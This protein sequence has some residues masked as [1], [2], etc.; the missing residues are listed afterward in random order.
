MPDHAVESPGSEA[1]DGA[2]AASEDAVLQSILDNWEESL[3]RFVKVMPKDYKR[4]LAQM[5]A[6]QQG[7][8]A[9]AVPA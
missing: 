5:E 7:A 2:P 1:A 8:R 3:P 6:E 9:T 4:A